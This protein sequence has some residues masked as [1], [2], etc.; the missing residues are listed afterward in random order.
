MN[1]NLALREI[2]DQVKKSFLL[3]IPSP[4]SLLGTQPLLLFTFAA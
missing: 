3:N 2:I 4:Y 1:K